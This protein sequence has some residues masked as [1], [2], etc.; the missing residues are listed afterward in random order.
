ME[1][2]NNSFV[3]GIPTN[4]S[5]CTNLD[6]LSLMYNNLIGGIALEIGSLIKLQTLDLTNNMLSGTI[7]PLLGN[8]TNLNR[9]S[10]ARRDS[11]V[12]PSTHKNEVPLLTISL[13]LFHWVSL[14]FQVEVIPRSL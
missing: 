3:G 13:L 7:P 9:L 14:I 11:G 2:G 1:L 5:Q 6:H 8:L 4:L 10:L 12:A